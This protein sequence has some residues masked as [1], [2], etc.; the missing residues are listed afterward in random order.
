MSDDYVGQ[1]VL[2]ING[3]EYEV[4]SMEPS[5]KTGRTVVKTMNKLGR[6]LGTAKGME[7]HDLRISVAIPKTGEPDWRALVDAKLTIYPQDGGSKRETWT[8]CSL[9]EMGSKYQVEGEATRDLTIV[10]LN[11]YEE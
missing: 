2:E 10:A 7:E 11:Y 4:V 6:P 9:V 1:I 8:G 5:L 3:T